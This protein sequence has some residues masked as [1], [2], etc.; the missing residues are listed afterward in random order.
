MSTTLGTPSKKNNSYFNT[1]KSCKG[2][3]AHW[4]KKTSKSF[5]LQEAWDLQIVKIRK[6]FVIITKVCSN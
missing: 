1:F 3:M 2:A 5:H 6:V 4:I